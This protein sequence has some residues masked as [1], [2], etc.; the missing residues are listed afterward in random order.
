[1]SEA[2]E[3]LRKAK[4]LAQSPRVSLVAAVYR[5]AGENREKR[6]KCGELLSRAADELGFPPGAKTFEQRK[7]MFDRAISLAEFSP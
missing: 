6:R 7:P 2:A 3:I 1:V 4:E 5:A